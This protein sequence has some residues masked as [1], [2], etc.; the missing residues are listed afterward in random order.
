MLAYV[1]WHRPASGVTAASYEQALSRFHHSLRRS[2][3][4]GFLGSVTLRAP[5]LPWLGSGSDGYE[6]WY[7]LESWA[8]LGV[9]EAA[10][11]AR[12]HLTA[13]EQAAR[14]SGV[15]A[16]AVY[17][18]LEGNG[19]PSQARLAV[20]VAPER[21]GS[22]PAIADLLGDGID[23]AAASLWR[24]ALVLGPAPELCLLDTAPALE[25]NTGLAPGRLPAGWTAVA[26][27]REPLPEPAPG[28]AA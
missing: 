23:P 26:A 13:H 11:V 9:L 28:S 17:R 14:R 1:Y 25:P 7:L 10:A 12:G 2:P 18:L 4:S 3:P 6:D 16:G 8:S 19:T 22:P 5:E 20:W 15:G 21:A 24:R 27:A